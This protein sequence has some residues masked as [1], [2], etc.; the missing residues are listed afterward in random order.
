M[1][2]CKNNPANLHSR[3]ITLGT[4]KEKFVF[5]RGRGSPNG[6]ELYW[7]GH[8]LEFYRWDDLF[9]AMRRGLRLG[10]LRL[11]AVASATKRDPTGRTVL[12][13]LVEI[14]LIARRFRRQPIPEIY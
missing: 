13:G 9:W 6:V 3:W 12:R 14:D 10:G 11:V 4:V 1:Q 7:P 5:S 2:I 8:V